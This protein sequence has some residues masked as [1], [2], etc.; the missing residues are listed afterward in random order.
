MSHPLAVRPANLR[1]LLEVYDGRAAG[2]TMEFDD[3]EI[4]LLGFDPKGAYC[5]PRKPIGRA[6]K[7]ICTC[8]FPRVILV[9]A[10]LRR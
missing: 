1:G 6:R 9:N 4:E 2:E 3:G 8:G 10:W 5:I 7:L